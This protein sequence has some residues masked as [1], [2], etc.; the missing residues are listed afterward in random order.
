[1]KSELVQQAEGIQEMTLGEQAGFRVYTGK[2]LVYQVRRFKSPLP[3]HRA[4]RVL[5]TSSPG[6][7]MEVMNASGLPYCKAAGFQNPA[8]LLAM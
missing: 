5:S 8:D 2:D 6:K 7:G 4:S 1:M 3:G